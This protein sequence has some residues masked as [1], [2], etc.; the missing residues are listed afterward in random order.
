MLDLLIEDAAIYD[1]TGSPWYRASVGIRGDRIACIGG[2]KAKARK[3]LRAAGLALCPGFVDVHTHADGIVGQPAAANF[4]QQGITTVVSGNC[5][6]SALPVA[7]RLREIEA[8]GPAINYATLVGHGTVRENAMGM[9]GRRPTR[10]EL[11]AMCRLVEQAMADGALGMST[12]LFYVPGSYAELDELVEVSKV[13]AAAGGVYA[14][15]KRSAGGQV[16]EAVAE[17]A[18][19]GRRARLPVEISHLKVLHR[20]GRTRPDRMDR[21]IEAI[22]SRRRDGVD[23]TFDIHPY[24]ATNTGLA[25]VAIPPWVSQDGKLKER[26]QDAAFRRRIRDE[27]A[28]KIAW[29]GGPGKVVLCTF[30][31]DRSLEGKTLAQVAK[32]RG[33]SAA[34]TAMDL[35]VEGDPS[36]MFHALRPADVRK[37]VAHELSMIAT[38]GHVVGDDEPV[39]HPRNFGTFPRI[40]REY[41]RER[42]LLSLP[43]AVRKMTSL[44]ARKFG[45]RDR[46]LIAVGAKADLVM[47]DPET[48]ADRTTYED[49]H[50]PADGLRTVIVN[51]H[52][53]LRDGRIARTRAGQVVRG[54]S[55]R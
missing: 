9:A 42:K 54:V 49:P 18:E 7:A 19:I 46:G 27:V 4:L 43:E 3:T 48:I 41:V 30:E 29:I 39:A 26:L 12:G 5:G 50:Q 22:E 21:V 31:P 24:G 10:K 36:A 16:F 14:S 38:D 20:R 47:F 34:D 6:G 37:V 2:P 45:I 25:A 1:G 23:I 52:V 28:G 11:L 32:A 53:A 15:H 55:C 33:R 17:A 8:A 35:V 51:G 13:V 44:P 40:L